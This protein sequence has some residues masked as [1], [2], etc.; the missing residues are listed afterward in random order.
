VGDDEEAAI[1]R[2]RRV[3]EKIVTR[4]QKARAL[5]VRAAGDFLYSVLL[6]EAEL[7]RIITAFFVSDPTWAVEF[8]RAVLGAK[9]PMGSKATM[10]RN[11][12]PLSTDPAWFKRA[13]TRVDRLVKRRNDIAHQLPVIDDRFVWRASGTRPTR[14]EGHRVPARELQEQTHVAFVLR[15]EIAEKAVPSIHARWKPY[16]GSFLYPDIIVAD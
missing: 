16:G 13:A 15:E 8:K 4:D 3:L 9:L 14:E 6:L 12:A 2:G 10:F 7:D 11:L 1:E 5:Y